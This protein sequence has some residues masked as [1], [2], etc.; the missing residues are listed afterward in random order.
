MAT[1]RVCVLRA[2]GTNCDY[3][4]AFAFEQSG[5]Q[6]D[7]VH[8]F[9]L[10]EDP[11]LLADYQVLCI[12]G[13]FS[14]GDDVGAG[15]VFATQLR[16]RLTEAI[17]NFLQRDTLTLGICNGFQVL[18]KAGILPGGSAGWSASTQTQ[19][20]A[21]LTWNANGRYTDLWVNLKV[22]SSKNVFLQGIDTLPCP[23][24]HGEGRLVVSDPAILADWK[25]NGQIALQYVDSKTAQCDGELLPFPVNPNGSVANI[26]GLGDATGRV[27]GLMPHP[28]RFL[29]ATQHP[30]WTRLGLKGDGE[31]FKLFRNAVAYF[32]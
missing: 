19:P 4:T 27:L 3:E 26:A 13:G 17:G 1:P 21:T 28:E 25:T 12:P 22:A 31:G 6:A 9:R 5:A 24:A 2:P 18:L 23:I 30:Q 8:L 32:G 10:L 16:H 11:K 15:V 20:P 7:R 29:F 14:Y